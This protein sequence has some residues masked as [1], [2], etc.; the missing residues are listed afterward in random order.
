MLCPYCNGEMEK[1]QLRSKGG[2]FFLPNG[3]RKPWVYAEWA[4]ERHHAVQLQPSLFSLF[5][6]YP[7]AYICRKCCKI[8]VEY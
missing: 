4:M 2:M 5:P 7:T 8:I 1:G 6:E 3:E